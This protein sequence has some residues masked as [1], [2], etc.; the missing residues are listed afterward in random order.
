[1]NRSER[2]RIHAA[3]GDEHRLAIVDAL[4][5]GDLSSREL[6]AVTGL[7]GNLLAHHLGVLAAA[8]L[9][10]RR[11]SEGDHRRRY[12]TLRS[13]RLLAA[14]PRHDLR[15]MS[16]LFVCTHNSARSQFAAA[17]WRRRGF[18]AQSAGTSPAAQVH[19]KAVQVGAE[20]GVDLSGMVPRGYEEITES[21]DVIVT[22]CD[23]ARE[24]ELPFRV[25]HR[26]W[27]VP[28]PVAAGT[29]TAFRSAFDEIAR[30]VDR[31]AGSDD[32]HYG[33]DDPP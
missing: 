31:L 29:L 32:E 4:A 2:A 1:M 9:V 27:S 26:H 13:E 16:V 12:V 7:P 23:R 20:R 30:R 8:G 6:A 21:P 14:S 11:V 3:L 5:L 17:L 24:S 19:P 28:D 22:V 33:G 10:E 18:A 15:A 25:E